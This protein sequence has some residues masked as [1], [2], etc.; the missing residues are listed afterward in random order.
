M[1]QM[2]TQ[3]FWYNFMKRPEAQA[4]LEH[5]QKE[6][7]LEVKEALE[8]D[9]EK[10]R[11]E[12]AE[13]LAKCGPEFQR[14][15][16]PIIKFH[17]VQKILLGTLEDSR[18]EN[19]DFADKVSN[20]VHLQDQ[21]RVLAKEFEAS[22]DNL[23]EIEQKWNKVMKDAEEDPNRLARDADDTWIPQ[24]TKNKRKLDAHMLKD[25]LQ[26]GTQMNNDG[27]EAY[28]KKDFTTALTKYTQAVRLYEWIEAT[29]PNDQVYLNEEYIRSLKNRAAAALQLHQYHEVIEACT[30]ALKL[31]DLDLKALYRRATAYVFLGKTEEARTDY[32]NIIRNPLPDWDAKDAAKKGLEKIAKVEEKHRKTTHKMLK[33]GFEQGVFGDDRQTK[34]SVGEQKGTT[35]QESTPTSSSKPVEDRTLNLEQVTGLMDELL[36]AY[37][38]EDFTQKMYQIRKDADY[39][40]GRILR[41]LRKIL[42]EV[43]GPI[44]T[45]YGF[46]N[47]DHDKN[48][49]AM[50]K[51]VSEWNDSETIKAKSRQIMQIIYGD[52]WDD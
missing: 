14:I 38:T 31:D 47:E 24:L 17:M 3:A 46:E 23:V 39:E 41:R 29:N 11:K 5:D 26:L 25:H 19:I 33:T 36:T 18:K 32:N 50:E 2:N 52:L 51:A 27:K 43:Q 48:R 30:E 45:K 10:K 20:N 21:M 12:L 13:E 15:I 1:D 22:P 16:S 9:R 7:L 8:K 35:S 40:E 37:Q 44:L 6:Q 28:E 34:E 42:P 49:M 4:A